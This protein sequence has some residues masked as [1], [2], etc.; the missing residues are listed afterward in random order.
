MQKTRADGGRYAPTIYVTSNVGMADRTAQ[1]EYIFPVSSSNAVQASEGKRRCQSAS[2]GMTMALQAAN[3][4]DRWASSSKRK[5][6]SSASE[7]H[8]TSR[9]PFPGFAQS[10]SP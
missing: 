2:A 7:T 3:R 10:S 5:V 8:F 6:L 1:K 4:N 9:I